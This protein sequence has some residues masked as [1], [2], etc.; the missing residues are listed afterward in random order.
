MI[1]GNVIRETFGIRYS[2]GFP[3]LPPWR[4]PRWRAPP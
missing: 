1:N 4:D 2:R 3:P